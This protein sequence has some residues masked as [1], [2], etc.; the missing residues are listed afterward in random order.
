MTENSREIREQ[1]QFHGRKVGR[2]ESER[3]TQ[4]ETSLQIQ[5]RREIGVKSSAKN[6]Q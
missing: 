1:I 6:E 2:I 4:I 5:I 3:R